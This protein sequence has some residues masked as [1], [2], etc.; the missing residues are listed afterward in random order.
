MGLKEQFAIWKMKKENKSDERTWLII[1][2]IKFTLEA[3]NAYYEEKMKDLSKVAEENGIDKKTL[4]ERCQ[5]E[6]ETNSRVL[7][8][9]E[10]ALQQRKEDL[11]YDPAEV[12]LNALRHRKAVL[13]TTGEDLK[14]LESALYDDGGEC[15]KGNQAPGKQRGQLF[16]Q[17]LEIQKKLNKVNEEIDLFENKGTLPENTNDILKDFRKAKY[18][19]MKH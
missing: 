7:K 3:E 5:K 8:N 17:R 18:K 14:N 13:E 4:I 1:R 12:I 9:V 19:E 11:G 16:I 6:I 10:K 2:N 15:F